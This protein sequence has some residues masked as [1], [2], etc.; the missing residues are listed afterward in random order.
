MTSCKPSAP[1]GAC[2]DCCDYEDPVADEWDQSIDA[3]LADADRQDLSDDLAASFAPIDIAEV[4]AGGSVQ[5][6]PSI[7]RRDDGQCLFY[8]GQINGVH[9]DSG[10]GKGW[11]TLLA[12][13]QQLRSGR[14]VMLIDL[15]DLPTSIIA[16]LRLLG[17]TDHELTHRL[18]YVRP[19]DPFGMTALDRLA[20]LIDN[21]AVALVIVDSLGE[22][23]ALDAIDENHDAEVAPW[24]RR[25][26]RRLADA[27][28]AVV[29]VD[30]STKAADN[31][32][33]PSGSK[34]K[35]AAV[36]GASYLVTAAT[37]LSAGNGGRLK[38]T[39]AK[40]RHGNYAR[41]EHVA[42]LVM[43]ADPV[44]GTRVE[45]Y[46]PAARS[47]S[48]MRGVVAEVILE[49]LTDHGEPCSLRRLIALLRDS[50]VQ[51]RDQ[52]IRD[53]VEVMVARRQ[54]EEITGPR[55]ARLFTTPDPESAS[56]SHRF[57]PLPDA[58]AQP[59]ETTASPRPGLGPDADAVGWS[60]PQQHAS[61]PPLPDAVNTPQPTP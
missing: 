49:V 5:P 56:A 28:P 1:C 27:G 12:I 17:A 26:A 31:P 57:P 2:D 3:L 40:D 50:S 14:T 45:L 48:D 47:E 41:S 59:T 58:V 18:I 38:I 61:Q 36:G 13:A 29:L 25:V 8:A 37:P 52:T 44:L 43:H 20:T 55:N 6:S 53:A 32:L 21:H 9:G 35:R 10:V 54:L 34:R 11:V 15:E 19:T 23:F 51:A 7:L 42:D 16:R 39:C 30:H 22:A 4:L 24:L 60:D 33:Y 46:A